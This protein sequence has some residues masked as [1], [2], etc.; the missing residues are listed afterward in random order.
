MGGSIGVAVVSTVAGVGGAAG[1]MGG[2][3]DA[4]LVCAV[5]AG[6][7]AVVS[8]ALV[9]RGKPEPGGAVPLH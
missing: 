5:A 3:A 1:T 7:C 9:P 8:A 6:G 2:F 4:F